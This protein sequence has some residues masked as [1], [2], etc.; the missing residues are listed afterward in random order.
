MRIHT[1]LLLSAALVFAIIP[2]V[3]S[4]EVW[5]APTD[6]APNANAPAPINVSG[7]APYQNQFKAGNLSVGRSDINDLK[8][9]VNLFAP[10]AKF[11]T[12]F[13]QNITVG[14][15]TNPM[16]RL[17][18]TNPGSYGRLVF[19]ETV[20][21]VTK[22]K[23]VVQSIGSTYG[24]ANRRNN[25]EIIT[26]GGSR[27]D[28]TLWTE[29]AER[30]RINSVGNVG[31]GTNAPSQKLQVAGKIYSTGTG[32]D[33][34][35][36]TNSDGTPD[37]CLSQSG[38]GSGGISS[39]TLQGFNGIALKDGANA[40]TTDKITVNNIDDIRVTMGQCASGS[41]FKSVN[42][43]W[44]CYGSQHT[45]FVA[46]ACVA[47]QVLTLVDVG[48]I[49]VWKCA[50]P[51][52]GGGAVTS[53]SAGAA[54][55]GF[56]VTA[57]PTTG[58]VVVRANPPA[59][60]NGVAGQVL[61][62]NGSAWIAGT[63]SI[64][65]SSITTCPNGQILKYYTAD[66]DGTG[67]K[68]V[69]W[70][71][72]A[73][74]SGS[75]GDN[76]GTQVV[77]IDS[78]TLT[79][80]GSATAL[81]A[82]NT[83]TLWDASQIQNRNVANTPPEVGQVLKWVSTRNRWEPSTDSVGSAPTDLTA[84]TVDG[85]V[86]KWNNTLV[87]WECGN[88]DNTAT[89]LPS[90]TVGQMLRNFN[91]TTWY[92][93]SVIQAPEGQD[94]VDIGKV[95][96]D[97]NYLRA[98]SRGNFG[99]LWF[100]DPN[101]TEKFHM[102]YS[103]TSF[104][105]TRTLVDVP[106]SIIDGGTTQLNDPKIKLPNVTGTG[107]F[108]KIVNDPASADNGLLSKGGIALSDLPTSTCTVPGQTVTGIGPTGV[109]CG[110]SANWS[111]TGNAGTNPATNF[112]GTT[113]A[114]PLVVRTGSPSL[115]RFRVTTTGVLDFTETVGTG[116]NKIAL[117]GTSYGLGVSSNQLNYLSGGKHSFFASGG[118]S[119]M[120]DIYSGG[121]GVNGATPNA[122]HRLA[123]SGGLNVTG[124]IQ[125]S[126][127]SIVR[128][129]AM[130]NDLVRLDLNDKSVVNTPVAGATAPPAGYGLALVDGNNM[131]SKATSIVCPAGYYMKGFS[132]QQG[133]ICERPVD[134]YTVF[135]EA[136]TKGDNEYF[137]L[138]VLGGQRYLSPQVGHGGL[139]VA[140]AEWR[141]AIRELITGVD[142][143]VVGGFWGNAALPLT[144]R[145]RAASGRNACDITKD[146][147]IQ[148]PATGRALRENWVQKSTYEEGFPGVWLPDRNGCQTYDGDGRYV[149]SCPVDVIE[150][151]CYD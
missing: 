29:S 102:A 111:L 10:I 24:V 96:A 14:N 64:G 107:S 33:V 67:P 41:L 95:N 27:G 80:D 93:T 43:N 98:G 8:D 56:G 51:A 74:L 73:D 18:F 117:Y 119:S 141:R 147:A 121:V 136:N 31:I 42:D 55:R 32:A 58:A 151:V 91:G 22:N 104:D 94:T 103:G 99:A 133:L 71:C 82:K 124:S 4:A 83:E 75:G 19:T 85:K 105:L 90:G 11:L 62:W 86:L 13:A 46:D 110:G 40:T 149:W 63:D 60:T 28:I 125:G 2:S 57:S 87:R 123:V 108:V 20:S 66:P 137:A 54:L 35:Y 150:V 6:S 118:V 12:L 135:A 122:T 61:K 144:S 44:A 9:G 49:P 130:T 50:N 77:T 48:G 100:V 88:D 116:A 72:D 92:P 128:P 30:M 120:L 126:A 37:K 138:R 76:W 142:D 17:D 143:P 1:S 53:V 115:E 79:G 36:D 106:V 39:F 21:G 34:C 112:I 26:Y 68:V 70:N 69:G 89:A 140:G 127:L 145:L 65:S 7:T 84:C 101:D 25:L 134:R 47:G 113:D 139:G 38:T 146:I 131:I 132:Q 23:S 109:V 129:L 15:P 52:S 5:Q 3:A 45:D 81:S 148:N 59:G 16:V 97:T 78:T 114:Q